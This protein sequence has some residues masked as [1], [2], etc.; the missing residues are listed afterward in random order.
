MRKSVDSIVRKQKKEGISTNSSGG[1]GTKSV[2]IDRGEKGKGSAQIPSKEKEK[3]KLLGSVSSKEQA[4][5]GKKEKKFRHCRERRGKG[6]L[7]IYKKGVAYRRPKEGKNR[8]ILIAGGGK[9]K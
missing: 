4:L 1:K 7:L 8:P 5:R 2:F 3:G 6:N 9:G